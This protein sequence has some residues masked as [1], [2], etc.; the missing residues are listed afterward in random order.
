[1]S[2][3]SSCAIRSVPVSEPFGRMIATTVV[4]GS[5]P[6]IR[7][8]SASPTNPVTPVTRTFLP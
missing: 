1:M 6:M 7:C 2:F 8:S 3:R 5:S 4:P